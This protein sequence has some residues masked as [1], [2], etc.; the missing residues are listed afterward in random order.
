MQL[1]S[2]KLQRS[3]E[4]YKDT[5]LKVTQSTFGLPTSA[6]YYRYIYIYSFCINS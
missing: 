3:A 1:L 5:L 2:A 4:V 6:T